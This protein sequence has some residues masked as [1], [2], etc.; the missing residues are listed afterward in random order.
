MQIQIQNITP[1]GQDQLQR[2]VQGQPSPSRDLFWL[3]KDGVCGHSSSAWVRVVFLLGFKWFPLWISNRIHS[4]SSP[5]WIPKSA[6]PRHRE[7][8][9]PCT[10]R[11]IAT[12]WTFGTFWQ[13][14]SRC[15]TRRSSTRWTGSSVSIIFYFCLFCRRRTIWT[16]QYGHM[17]IWTG[18][19]S[20][21]SRRETKSSKSSTS[22]CHLFLLSWYYKFVLKIPFVRNKKPLK[23]Y[24]LLQEQTPSIHTPGF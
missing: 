8:F 5:G 3:Q 14:I 6:N 18:W 9:Q 10:W 23:N 15:Q 11:S 17:D 12:A 24:L 22:F 16:G 7:T 2:G 19:S 4:G 20:P 1:G 21:D 13:N